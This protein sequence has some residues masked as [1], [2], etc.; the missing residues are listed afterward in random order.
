METDPNERQ[1]RLLVVQ[2]LLFLAEQLPAVW[3]A[4][5]REDLLQEWVY[6][7]LQWE[8]DDQRVFCALQFFRQ[9]LS[10]P[11]PVQRRGRSLEPHSLGHLLTLDISAAREEPGGPSA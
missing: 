6:D 1:V 4:L 5:L 2:L 10:R 7:F 8:N 9:L 11:L 3:E